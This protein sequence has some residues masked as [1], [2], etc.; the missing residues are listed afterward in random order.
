MVFN[1]LF[2]FTGFLR[3]TEEVSKTNI[4]FGVIKNYFHSINGVDCL[5]TTT[6]HSQPKSQ[7]LKKKPTCH[8]NDF[9]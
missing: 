8:I 3:P 9:W 7:S 1:V 6:E 4:S 5:R 2:S